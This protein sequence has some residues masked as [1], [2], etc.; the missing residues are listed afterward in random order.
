MLTAAVL[1]RRAVE[2]GNA[3]RHAAARRALASARERHPD[4][5]LAGLI[6]GTWA[7]IASE[8]GHPD[9]DDAVANCTRALADDGLSGP[10]R[11]VLLS[12]LGLVALRRGDADA[13]LPH[14][15]AA[16]ARLGRDP[17]R[18]G[19]VLLNRGMAHLDRSEATAAERDFARAAAA[20]ERADDAVG[21]AKAQN[22]QGYAAM[23]RGDPVSALRLMDASAVILAGLSPASAAVGDMDR[24][25]ML[26]AAGMTSEAVE[27][28]RRA[29]R[30]YGG[31]G[32]RQAQGE[33]ELLLARSLALEDPLGAAAAA[34]SAA[35]R[36]RRRGSTAWAVR[37][38]AAAIASDIAGGRAGASVRAAASR[39]AADLDALRRPDEAAALR[40]HRVRALLGAGEVAAAR[41]AAGRIR[42]RR[43]ASVTTRLLADEV[44]VELLA[45]DGRDAAVLRRAGAG[46]AALG[47]WQASFGSL[48]LF[49]GAAVHGRRLAVQGMRAALRTGRPDAVL[50]WS[51]RIRELSASVARMRPPAR[52]AIADALAELRAARA[53]GGPSTPREA[54]LR[55]SIRRSHW[56]DGG[57]GGE[58]APVTLDAVAGAAAEDDAVLIAHLW[59]GERVAALVVDARGGAIVDLAGTVEVAALLDGLLVDLDTAAAR[60]PA[61][62]SATVRGA[63]EIRLHRLDELLLAP[64][65]PRL[66]G[67]RRLV[68]TPAGALAGV[69]WTMLPS[70]GARAV[71]VPDSASAWLRSRTAPEPVVSAGFVAGPGVDRAEEE[72]T[73]ASAHWPHPA[74]LVGATATAAAVSALAERVD[75]LHIAAHGRHTA[76]NPLFSA[77]ELVDGPWFGYDVDQLARVPSVVVLSACELGRSVVR[78]GLEALS[79]SRAWLHAGARSVVASPSAVSDEEAAALLSATHAH[80][81][82]G[83]GPAD[84]LAAAQRETGIRAPFLCRGGGW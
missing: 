45:R 66:E 71:A 77:V 60:L 14:L 27:L 55:Q 50:A 18:L 79:G 16:A 70:A 39:I 7:Y 35:R 4:P 65:A 40:L 10:T 43:S 34:R 20:F 81:A 64:L 59:T 42:V 73:A 68:L 23:L 58:R 83:I 5:D 41:E 21:R 54:E 17:A 6:A 48:E 29:A 52:P 75:L 22:N 12:Q 19:Q 61:G 51:E 62:L 49:S 36:F 46:L 82:R 53:A 67:A 11:A 9:A 2:H 72:I 76:E 47:D 30:I 26:L 56:A 8:S 32:L 37:A 33:A 84:A 31:R 69:P 38:E 3:G 63:L 80:L 24:A 1:Y 15:T 57:R 13:A 78:G 25:E 44:R 74:A 28:L